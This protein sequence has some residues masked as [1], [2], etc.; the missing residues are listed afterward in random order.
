MCAAEDVDE[1]DKN[2]KLYKEI[3]ID[4]IYDYALNYYF[5]TAMESYFDTLENHYV[6]PSVETY[7]KFNTTI[8]QTLELPSP[9]E[10]LIGQE[11]LTH[12]LSSS[13]KVSPNQFITSPVNPYISIPNY[14]DAETIAANFF[15]AYVKIYH[16]EQ[17]LR[18]KLAND[19][20][21]ETITLEQLGE[22]IDILMA[23]SSYNFD[24]TEKIPFL[25]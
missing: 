14:I 19:I 9:L 20:D 18:L 10:S 3:P 23:E 15:N 1:Q 24:F 16:I 11:T 4:E 5:P 8:L 6:H 2:E 12:Y 25:D 22:K 13:V 21:I 7:D 17:T